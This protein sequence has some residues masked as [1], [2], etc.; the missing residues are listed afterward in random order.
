MRLYAAYFDPFKYEMHKF[1]QFDRS[2][3][4]HFCINHKF[5]VTL[6]AREVYLDAISHPLKAWIPLA[7][8]KRIV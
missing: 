2:A 5:S 7:F 6:L 1:T 8:H 3:N 4:P